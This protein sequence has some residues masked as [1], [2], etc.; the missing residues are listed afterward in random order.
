MTSL[1]TLRD[2]WIAA[3][4]AR[5]EA[6]KAFMDANKDSPGRKELD[7]AENREKA[8]QRKYSRALQQ[9]QQETPPDGIDTRTKT[10]DG[11]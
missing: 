9:R 1:V 2:E 10:A 8:A 6:Y 5:T 4:N 3:E 7:A 11:G